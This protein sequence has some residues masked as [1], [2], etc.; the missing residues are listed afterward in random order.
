MYVCINNYHVH[1]H[2]RT[3]PP[4]HTHTHILVE[5][6]LVCM[7]VSVCV[8]AT[9]TAE[10]AEAYRDALRAHVLLVK[11]SL[12]EDPVLCAQL[13]RAKSHID[14]SVTALIEG[15]EDSGGSAKAAACLIPRLAKLS[16]K[17]I[18]YL[19]D[20]ILPKLGQNDLA[21]TVQRCPGS[22]ECECEPDEHHKEILASSTLAHLATVTVPAVIAKR[23]SV[24]VSVSGY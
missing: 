19:V 8:Y 17:G 10:K 3:P 20:V 4:T 5:I 9:G 22:D 16:D 23:L 1:G 24:G 11:Q 18:C 15:A 6:V 14:E 13:L 2:S 21:L 7:Y 12:S